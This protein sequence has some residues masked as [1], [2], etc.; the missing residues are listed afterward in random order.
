MS[1][2]QGIQERDALPEKFVTWA[3]SMAE[4]R[5]IPGKLEYITW[6]GLGEEVFLDFG[7]ER[8]LK[9]AIPRGMLAA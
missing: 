4:K 7:C 1:W 6:F 3:D 8:S 2:D 9:V 5:G